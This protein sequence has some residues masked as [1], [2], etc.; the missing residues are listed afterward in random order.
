[1]YD[2]QFDNQLDADE[3]YADDSHGFVI[4]VDRRSALLIEGTSIDWQVTD[5]GR[6]GFQFDNPN[7]VQ[8]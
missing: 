4:L 6:E 3:D 2:L 5:D 1:M 7:A 8:E